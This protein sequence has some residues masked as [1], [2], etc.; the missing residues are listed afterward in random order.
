MAYRCTQTPCPATGPAE[1]D[2][3]SVV[4]LTSAVTGKNTAGVLGGTSAG[5]IRWSA[6]PAPSGAQ[7]QLI[8]FWSR[9][10]FAQPDPFSEEGYTQLISSMETG[11][12]A[13]VRELMKANGGDLFYDS[14]SSDRGS[15]DELWTNKMAEEFHIRRQYPLIP[16]LPALFRDIF[17]FSDG[18]APRVRNDLYAVRG[19]IW[20][21]KQLAP[22]GPGCGSTTTCC[23]SRS[24]E[25]PA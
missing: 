22:C 21:E 4:D 1:L 20:L 2:R 19:D 24:R 14:H 9:G 13:E 17:S 3:S 5:D 8:A 12:S 10:V 23:A 6:P 15:P 25:R 11:L 18:S 16:N 7:W